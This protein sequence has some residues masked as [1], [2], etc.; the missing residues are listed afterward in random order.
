MFTLL[1]HGGRFRNID[2]RNDSYFRRLTRDMN[3]GETLLW[4]GFA[5]Q[6]MQTRTA[7]FE[8]EKAQTLRQTTKNIII[9]NATIEHFA[10]Q[11]QR[12]RV[13]NI[14]GGET[15]LLIDAFRRIPDFLR[16]LDGKLVGG[17]SAGACMF[18][19]KYWDGSKGAF[20]DGLGVVPYGL[21][22]HYGSKE[23]N[24]TKTQFG[25]FAA[26]LPPNVVPL[27]LEE[28]DWLEKVVNVDSA[29]T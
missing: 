21:F 14:S 8:H 17:S 15:Q 16:L 22:V 4:V 7:R 10:E 1:L 5:A 12:A 13:V 19:R 23:F 11:L 27:A 20:F 25:Q 18:C 29:R 26:Q 24:A 9:E 28:A 3:D 2:P 6:D